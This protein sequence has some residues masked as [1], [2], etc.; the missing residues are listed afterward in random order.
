MLVLDWVSTHYHINKT[1]H[2]LL[3]ALIGG[4]HAGDEETTVIRVGDY[5]ATSKQLECAFKNVH[6]IAEQESIRRQ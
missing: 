6:C 3:V 1:S 5:R 2:Y 4:L